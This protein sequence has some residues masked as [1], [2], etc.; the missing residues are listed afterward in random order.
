MRV[1]M[2]MARAILLAAVAVSN[3]HADCGSVDAAM[4]AAL[5]QANEQDYRLFDDIVRE[6][7]NE[8]MDQC[9]LAV[10]RQQLSFDAVFREFGLPSNLLD[11]LM[12][13]ACRA[14]EN[15]I[16]RHPGPRNLTVPPL[17]GDGARR[18]AARP[19]AVSSPPAV[20]AIPAP[21]SEAASGWF[22]WFS[23]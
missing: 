20:F 7:S 1:L 9:I 16:P 21:S 23:K 15:A 8:A 11:Q 10:M 22:D 5:R 6:T 4:G 17:S 2:P 13:Q 3:A 19:S 12:R 18:A 14:L